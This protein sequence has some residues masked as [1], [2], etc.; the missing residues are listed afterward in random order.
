MKH[1]A[2][3]YNPVSGSGDF[4]TK[5][6]WVTEA[7]QKR[8]VTLTLYRTT[9]D[10]ESLPCFL[11]EAGAEGILVAG[12]DGTLHE[13][14][15]TIKQ[16]NLHLPVGI[17]GSGTSN[18][19]ASYLGITDDLE[20]YFD[21]VA[22][23]RTRYV[24]LGKVGDKFFVNVASAGVMTAIAHEVP[25]RLKNALGKAAYY[26]RGLGE[27][28]KFRAVPMEITADGQ[29]YAAE[30]FLFVII[31]SAVVGSLKNVAVDAKID[32][33]LLDL[34]AI[35]K[36]G[37]PDLMKVTSDL[38]AGNTV[39]GHKAILHLQA[40][41]FNIASEANLL[42]DLDGEVGP[43]LPLKVTAVPGALRVYG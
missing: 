41:E 33:G 14:V 11:R 15:N 21:K 34:L 32:D 3:I 36:C 7:L 30:F 27:L 8:D 23:G 24:D 9:K 42:S 17:I 2:L 35:K 10:N 29:S 22:L 25:A 28:P 6:D 26:I 1:L 12:G 4:K 5:L 19:F 18:D 20:S 43:Y 37:L 16:E 38:I 40:R 31:N 13:A 39:T